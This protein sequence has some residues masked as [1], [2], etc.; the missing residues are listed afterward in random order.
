M[1]IAIE[2]EKP[3]DP[4]PQGEI[5]NFVDNWL[6]SLIYKLKISANDTKWT[7]TFVKFTLNQC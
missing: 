1:C 7:F 4:A 6:E 5:G 3:I 2:S